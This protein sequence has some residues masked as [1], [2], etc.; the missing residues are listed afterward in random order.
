MAVVAKPSKLLKCT[1]RFLIYSTIAGV[2]VIGTQQPSHALLFDPARDSIE[3]DL[4]ASGWTDGGAAFDL[5]F[6]LI[7]ALL[8]I[9][10][11]ASG[12]AALTQLNR[13]AEGWMPWVS[14]M[15][16]SVVFIGFATFLTNAIFA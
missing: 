8:L 7:E 11:V 13:G 16:A 6:G 12:I 3:A 14:V 15:G 10:P 2:V 1:I 9:I 5:V 4:V